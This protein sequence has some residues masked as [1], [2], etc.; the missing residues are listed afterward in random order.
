[1][2]IE[3]ASLREL[4]PNVVA[5]LIGAAVTLMAAL[6][7]LRIAWRREVLARLPT[8]RGG[9]P[10]RGLLP[11]IGFLVAAAAVGGYAL[12]LYLMQARDSETA[13]LRTELRQRADQIQSSAERIEG[14]RTLERTATLAEAAAI[15][16]RRRGAEGVTA[17]A[18]LAP[19]RA[20]ADALPC[21]E[22]EAVGTAVCATL[23]ARAVAS[24]V[25]VF[26]ILSRSDG[27]AVVYAPSALGADLGSA[28]IAAK[29]FERSDGSSKQLC[30]EAWSWD[31]ARTLELRI[32]A[33]YLISEAIAPPSGAASSAEKSSRQALASVR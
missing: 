17:A 7:N 23:P 1:M 31:S 3:F 12:A 9:K 15:E 30:V 22:E 27:A 18:R 33:K 13:L 6:I 5:A 20:R 28:R 11:A 26:A 14:A 25:A 21:R 19:C 32:V 4:S 16:E 29:P 24:E 10:R 2:D 8:Q